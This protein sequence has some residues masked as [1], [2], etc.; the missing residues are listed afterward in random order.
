MLEIEDTIFSYR[1]FASTIPKMAEHNEIGK[2][3]ENI[4]ANHLEKSGYRILERNWRFQKAE[5][6]LIT[7]IQEVIAFVEVKT[8]STDHFGEPETAVSLKKQQLILKAA[9]AYVE[10]NDLDLEVRFDII[11]VLMVS[12][13]PEINHITDAFYPI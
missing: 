11:S 3:G 1:R 4:A 8:R 10:Q 6:D 7:Q 12:P 5:I 2:A 13:K 9:H